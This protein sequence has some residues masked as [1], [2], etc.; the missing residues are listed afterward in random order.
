MKYAC[1]W[2]HTAKPHADSFIDA[3]RVWNDS[4][5]PQPNCQPQPNIQNSVINYNGTLNAKINKI[6][7]ND[8]DG[9]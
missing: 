4:G 6:L 9:N 8:C 7:S 5:Q 1:S 2:R 3:H